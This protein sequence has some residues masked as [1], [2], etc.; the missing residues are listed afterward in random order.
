MSAVYGA[1]HYAISCCVLLLPV[2]LTPCEGSKPRIR[3]LQIY[4]SAKCSKY[5]FRLYWD[6]PG[7]G[8]TQWYSAGLRAG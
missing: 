2:S 5:H 8:I 7:A 6:G 1:H 4:F 3:V